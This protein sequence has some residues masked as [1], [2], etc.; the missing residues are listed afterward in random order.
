MRCLPLFFM[1]ILP[2]KEILAYPCHHDNYA[3]VQSEQKLFLP[4]HIVICYSSTTFFTKI[5]GA[6]AVNFN[7]LFFCYKVANQVYFL[8][9]IYFCNYYFDC[10]LL[11][12]SPECATLKCLIGRLETTSCCSLWDPIYCISSSFW[13]CPAPLGYRD[14]VS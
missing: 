13:S 3:V 6:F 12:S 14:T 11:L 10:F 2:F 8:C 1:Y 5:R 9:L 7:L 4:C